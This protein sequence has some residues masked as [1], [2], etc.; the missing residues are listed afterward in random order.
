MQQLVKITSPSEMNKI[1]L[2]HF[3]KAIFVGC[4][5]DYGVHKYYKTSISQFKSNVS[6][7]DDVWCFID[8]DMHYFTE[9]SK[10]SK[11]FKFG[12]SNGKHTRYNSVKEYLDRNKEKSNIMIDS[13]STISNNKVH[14]EN[15][16]KQ[17]NNVLDSLFDM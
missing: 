5:E 12:L 9:T 4:S 1:L 7:W 15:L 8:K 16:I 11:L 14:Q 17:S 3:N 2:G 10:K 6:E 13:K